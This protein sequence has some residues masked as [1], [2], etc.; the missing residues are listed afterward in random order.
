MGCGTSKQSRA[1]LLPSL[2]F[3]AACVLA[4]AS[5]ALSQD[6]C[7]NRMD[8]GEAISPF[9]GFEHVIFIYALAEK[10]C[11]APASSISATLLSVLER[12]GC[13]PG[14]H[15]YG[16]VEKAVEPLDTIDLK[17]LAAWAENDGVVT[18]SQ[19]QEWAQS[20]VEAYGGCPALLNA[21]RSI[22]DPRQQA[23]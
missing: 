12:Q 17:G 21:H 18:P 6:I 3:A 10:A 8:K 2:L 5:P 13:G 19:V 11:G 23:E 1:R 9:F 22:V 7:D 16:L 15:I 14:T 20:N 4:G